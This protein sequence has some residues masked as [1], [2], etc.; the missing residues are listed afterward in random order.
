M[1]RP[2]GYGTVSNDN[3]AENGM[4]SGSDGERAALLSKPEDGNLVLRR[5][6]GH[7]TVDISKAWGDLILLGCYI[8]TGLL[9]SSSVQVWGSFV[10]MQTGNTIY[11][12]L[13]LAAPWKSNR[14]IRAGISV[15]CFCIGSFF[16]ARFHRYLGQRK[17]WVMVLSFTIQII[18]MI[19]A[20]L[21][22]TLGPVTGTSDPVTIW[23]SLPIALIAFQSAGQAVSSRVLG[24]NGLTSVVLTS[25][26]CDLFMDPKLLTAS[27]REN[28]ERNRRAAAAVC[29]AVGAFFG[30]LWGNSEYGLPGALWTAIVLKGIVIV[31]WFFWKADKESTA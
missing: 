22:V 12:G 2:N 9:D 25:I 10:S 3:H 14:W 8:I 18:L 1:A 16:F 13:G 23:I 28:I 21:M 4:L 27:P 11:F 29:V 7:M 31:L 26:Y 6:Q 17:R 5:I 19:I 20:A 30:G 15:G 24:Y